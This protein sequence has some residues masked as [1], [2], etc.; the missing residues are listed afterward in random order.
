MAPLSQAQIGSA[1]LR[2]ANGHLAG[3]STTLLDA[4][5]QHVVADVQLHLVGD[6][7]VETITQPA[8]NDRHDDVLYDV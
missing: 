4:G 2:R 8:V 6:L 5:T 7:L 3:V 1:I